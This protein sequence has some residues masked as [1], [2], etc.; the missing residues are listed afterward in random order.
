MV[1]SRLKRA[2]LGSLTRLAAGGQ[3]VVHRAPGVSMQY[4]K[5]M[6][7]KEYKSAVLPQVAVDV[8]EEMPRYLESLPFAEGIDLLSR[9][10]WPCRL[11]EED[12]SHRVTGFVMPAI[13]DDFFVDLIVSSGVQRR[14]AEFQ[15]LLNTDD[16]LARRGIPLSDRQRYELLSDAAEALAL[17]HRHNIAV[18]DLSPKN[19]LF[20]LLPSCTVYFID[21]DAMR[22]AGRSVTVQV[23]TPDW[24]VRTVNAGEEL[25][26]PRSD[27]YKFGLLALRLLAGDQ[28]TRDPARLPAGV[29]MPVRQL[30][31]AALSSTPGM[32]PLPAAWSPALRAA[33]HSAATTAAA[34][35]AAT[36]PVTAA[37]RRPPFAVP[38]S[39]PAG[40]LPVSPQQPASPPPVPR[41]AVPRHPPTRP[42]QRARPAV[43]LGAL[44]I[45]L[46]V[47]CGVLIGV[48]NGD[49]D[50][51][52]TVGATAVRPIPA[53]VTATLGAGAEPWG[54]AFDA[55]TSTVFTTNSRSNSISVY[56]NR[57][58]STGTITAPELAK[59][60][61]IA[62]DSAAGVAY[63]TNADGGSV[64]VLRTSDR[65][66]VGR[67]T[68]GA[69]PYG[70]A[71]DPNAKRAYVTNFLADTV[72]VIDTGSNTVV[73]TV[74]VGSHPYGIAVD[75]ATK[76]VF[77]AN[78]GTPQ[79]PDRRVSVL[80][81]SSLTI[82]GTIDVGNR[83]YGIAVDAGAATAYVTN[84]QDST[85][86]VID[87]RSRVVRA[88]VRVGTGPVGVAVDEPGRAVYVTNHGTDANPVGNTVSVLASRSSTVDTTVQVGLRPHGVT[89]DPAGRRLY[90]TNF[91]DGTV[92]V[93]GN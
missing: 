1:L 2:H 27:A 37:A 16:F 62:V 43:L 71:L 23:E 67:I 64:S 26:T 25:A 35:P 91:D 59:P 93:L 11:V 54:V 45:A 84:N 77:V 47:L 49:D 13:P 42:F 19:M 90:V 39:P 69:A 5:A 41:G 20:S 68:V 57:T 51:A 89:V 80:S 3:G 74:A 81:T 88:T 50:S 82:V 34:R 85:V 4:A 46:V 21:C 76:S 87:T 86:S 48:S 14:T 78:A 66:F 70:I 28:C 92:S 63:I 40:W 55:R 38:A 17:L 52:S 10:A 56:D 36:R 73:T 72:S 60:A 6:V 61:A 12:N 7:Y 31:G 33:A 30:V 24:E 8:L 18:G 75:P 44:A 83:P 32:R 22:L 53:S 65:A 58:R 79:L 15:H 9:V 29:P